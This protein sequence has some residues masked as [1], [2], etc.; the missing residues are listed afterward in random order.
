[1]RNN[2]LIR[3]RNIL[4]E[5]A[6]TLIER[7]WQSCKTWPRF[8]STFR[9]SQKSSQLFQGSSLST[10]RLRRVRKRFLGSELYTHVRSVALEIVFVRQGHSHSLDRSRLFDRNSATTSRKNIRH[11]S[12]GNSHREILMVLDDAPWRK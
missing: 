8:T 1:M 5:N 6:A 10:S 4:I 3:R 7:S 11:V 12:L 9:I 2:F